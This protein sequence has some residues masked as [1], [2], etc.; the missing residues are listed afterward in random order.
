MTIYIDAIWLLNFGFDTLLL[1][2]TLLL[3]KEKLIWWRVILG[4]LIG[5][6]TVWL[7]IT[8]YAYLLDIFWIKIAIS[9]LMVAMIMSIRKWRKF[10]VALITFYLVTFLAGGMLFGLHSLLNSHTSMVLESTHAN[11]NL[12]GD[13]VSWLF[14]VAAFPITFILMKVFTRNIKVIQYF[15]KQ[16]VQAVCE[17]N[18]YRLPLV[19]FVDT[20]NQLTD[21]LTGTPIVIISI[22]RLEKILPDEML[23]MIRAGLSPESDLPHEWQERMRVI[24]YKVVGHDR[25]VMLAFK[26]DFFEIDGR[27]CACLIAF[28]TDRLSNKSQYNAII[29]PELMVG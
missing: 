13:E 10:L 18:S 15:A 9:L 6:A 25:N 17:I 21:P 4:G 1:M 7:Y 11:V 22:D 16:Q 28:T 29:H 12:Y 19:G 8:P 20:G 24:P 27:H 23:R 26:P 14:V 5:S 2:W 3:M